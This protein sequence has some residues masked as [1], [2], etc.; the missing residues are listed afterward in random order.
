[1]LIIDNAELLELVIVPI[2]D[3]VELLELNKPMPEG[4]TV[5]AVE[6]DILATSAIDTVALA[7]CS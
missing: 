1:M 3:N 7:T 4:R 6:G 2:L 5:K